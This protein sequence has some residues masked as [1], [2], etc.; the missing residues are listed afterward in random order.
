MT[1]LG[2]AL[3]VL[4]AK[5]LVRWTAQPARNFVAATVALTAASIVPDL[6]VD[7]STASRLVLIATHVVAAAIVIPALARRLSTDPSPATR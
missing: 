2:A 6:T 5:A 4:L 7:A 3:G 1:L